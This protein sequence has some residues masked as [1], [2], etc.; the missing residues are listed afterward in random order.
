[1]NSHGQTLRPNVSFASDIGP[2]EFAQLAS[3]EEMCVRVSGNRLGRCRERREESAVNG[4]YNN[5]CVY[6][7]VS[8]VGI[9]NRPTTLRVTRIFIFI[10]FSV[11]VCDYLIFYEQFCRYSTLRVFARFTHVSTYLCDLLIRV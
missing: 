8:A 11:L 1:M 10:V 6:A 3:S 2:D 4:S 9:L 5:T 7:A